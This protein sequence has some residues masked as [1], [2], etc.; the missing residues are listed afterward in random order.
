MKVLFFNYEYPPLGAG[1]AN[2]TFFI[3]K[4][5]SKIPGLEVDLVTS[6]VD[7]KYHLIEVGNNVRVHRINIGKNK[8]NFHFQSQKDLLVYLFQAYFFSRKL[9]KK[10]KKSE[11]PFDMTHSFFTVPCGFISL[12]L[13]WQY[14]LPYIV[15]LRGSDVPGY[16][17]RFSLMYKLYTPVIKLIWKKSNAV[18]S[19]SQGLKELALKSR[20]NQEMGIIYNG[21]DIDIFKPDGSK[22]QEGKFVITT[23]ATRIATRKGIKYL[24]EAIKN[25]SPKYPQM[26]ARIMGEGEGKQELKELVEKYSLQ[27]NVEFLGRMPIHNLFPFY[28]EANVFVLPSLN[29]GMCN[30]LLEA[31]GAGL[32]VIM[33]PTGGAEELIKDG[34]NGYIIKFKDAKDIAEKLEKMINDRELCRKMGEESRRIAE[35]MSWKSVADKYHNL[36]KKSSKS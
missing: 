5:F 35:T 32:P 30:A 9:I 36:Y 34:V 29:E 8:N 14:K 27:K 10:A 12:L 4:E 18:I 24:I 25:L 16:S 23:G 7:D 33:T 17:D 2:A 21:I 19:N 13:K 28:Q 3:L 11:K 20:P 26:L 1:A 15:S 22:R 6:S 31:L